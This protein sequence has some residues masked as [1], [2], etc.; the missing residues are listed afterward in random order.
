MDPARTKPGWDIEEI[1]CLFSGAGVASDT[2]IE[3]S[4]SPTARLL[5][6]SE[7][8]LMSDDGLQIVFGTGQVGNALAAYLAGLGHPVRTVSRHRPAALAGVDWRSA[9]AADPEAAADAAK[10]AAVIY[11]CL[12]APYNQWPERF[13]PF[14]NPATG[15]WITYTAVAE[16]NNGQLVRFTW[17]SVPG[18][19]ITEHI[20]PRQEERFT[21][22]AG[23]AHFTLNG[24]EYV[25]GA[26]ETVVVPC[27]CAAFGGKPRTG[28]DRGHRRAAPG[29]PRQGTA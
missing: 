3:V 9:D 6:V 27:R 2:G 18:G 1:Y 7:D 28:R 15:E 16:D 29:A 12:N 10:G 8:Q 25:A 22:V 5:G 20:H 13:R 21:I 24:Q 23:Q 19:V 4:L 26:G 14:F 17:R 11:Q